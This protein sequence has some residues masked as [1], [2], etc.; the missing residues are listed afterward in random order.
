MMKPSV[1]LTVAAMIAGSGFAQETPLP[2]EAVELPKYEQA[3]AEHSITVFFGP[4]DTDVSPPALTA[5]EATIDMIDSC[6]ITEIHTSAISTDAEN[7]EEMLL[8]SEART[9]SVLEAFA[10]SGVWAQ[11]VQTDIVAARDTNRSD[12]AEEPLA[13]RV[14]VTL[15]TAPVITS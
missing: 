12:T 2:P 10:A 13:R 4:K 14:E 1:L 6:A 3:C 15:A 11:D 5:L 9:D 8:L 7:S